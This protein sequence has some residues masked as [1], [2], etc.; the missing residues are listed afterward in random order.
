MDHPP[1][2]PL[3]MKFMNAVSE[4]IELYAIQKIQL[5]MPTIPKPLL[6][7]LIA[8]AETDFQNEPTLID[9]QSPCTI[10]GD[11]H[12]HVLDLFRI[13]KTQGLPD[14]TKYVFLGDLVDR[15]EFSIEVIAMVYML[16]VLYPNNVFLLRGNHEFD[17]L[18]SQCGFKKQVLE[19][20]DDTIYKA[21]LSS[22]SYIPLAIR[23]DNQILC[24]HGG[25]GPTMFSVKQIA[26][27]EKPIHEFGP[28]LLDAL[29]W[30][31]PNDSV[32]SFEPSTRG[33]GFFF[34][35]SALDEFLDLSRLQLLI[36]GHECV[37][38]GYESKF[39]SKLITVFSASNYCGI[40]RNQSAVMKVTG[41][42]EYSFVQF[43]PLEYLR[44]PIHVR[45]MQRI[46]T[47]L[48]N[49]LF[50]TPRFNVNMLNSASTDPNNHAEIRKFPS[51]G[52]INTIPSQ[53][54]PD[55]GSRTIPAT[56]PIRSQ[57]QFPR[58]ASDVMITLPQINPTNPSQPQ[59]RRMMRRHSII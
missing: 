26:Q 16:K 18:A 12:G 38:D 30:S 20:Y 43:D 10:V 44:R 55:F 39:D 28:E 22:F 21:F 2:G 37:M 36:R 49:A 33:T 56:G 34:S 46:S 9:I 54:K 52:G 59:P 29:L 23:I 5:Q 1:F 25:I 51:F 6:L 8:A 7:Q 17:F 58:K 27:L 31:D 3:F 50:Q 35:K 57:V 53:S 24:V 42:N 32:E 19:I 4:D 41:P 13:L 40:V 11:I 15:G 45:T 48:S 47:S 14:S